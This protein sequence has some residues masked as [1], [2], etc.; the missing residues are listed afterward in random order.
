MNTIRKETVGK[1]LY[2]FV[3]I[4]ILPVSLLLWAN[5]TQ[6]VVRIQPISSVT[7]GAVLGALG[8]G[9]L[10]AG[11]I[12]LRV[13]GKGL[14]MNLFPPP[15]FVHSGIYR[16]TPHPIYT[17]FS[18]CCLAT[19]VLLRSSSGFWFIS[20]IA[21]LGCVA[22]VLGFERQDLAERFGEHSD[23]CFLSL[24]G[25]EIRRPTASERISVYLLVLLPWTM[26]YEA[27]AFIGV[28]PDAVNG[29]L[30]M[31]REIPVV[32]WTEFFYAATY[33][34]VALLPL[35]AGSA[36]A[37]R[38]FSIAGLTATVAMV[39]FFIG[40]PLIAS[41]RDFIPHGIFGKL[42]LFER[43][44][45]TPAAA[46]PSYHVIWAIIGAH[47]YTES[48]PR[49]KWIWRT[50][51]GLIVL[52]CMTTGM[53]T[54]VDV[55]AGAV[56]GV[57]AA[58][59]DQMWELLRSIA[60][61]VSNSWKEWRFGKVRIINHGAYPAVGTALGIAIVGTLLGS[62]S[63]GYIILV[64]FVSLILAGLWAQVIEGSSM[65]LRPYGYYGGVLGVILGA[66][67]AYVLGGN[68]W[69]LLGAYAVA[70]PVIQAFGRI[71]CLVQG[72]CH[73]REAPP[74]IGIR[75]THPRSRVVRLANLSGVPVYPTPLYSIL[76]NAGL[77]LVL[78]RLWSLRVEP[79]FVAGVY[80][81]LNGLG[82]FVEEAYRGEPQTPILGKLRLYQIMAILSVVTGAVFTSIRSE[83]ARAPS[84]NLASVAAAILF[85]LVTWFALGVDFPESNRRFARLT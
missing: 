82:R 81:I 13:Y 67:I 80:L 23:R 61:R 37:L 74:F 6:A 29:L 46:F 48:F 30:P 64:A 69:G 41:P 9:L 34:F 3:F 43:S 14:P 85:G 49:L 38:R 35:V 5:V 4:V 71:R 28:P 65:L 79:S 70:A 8:V 55:A 19:S 78:L 73:G 52:S 59:Y 83:P 53:H 18:L 32:E 7:L 44:V 76:W 20:P 10:L 2:G 1:V 75:Y 24:P 47:A 33:I 25:N 62:D 26:A 51:A 17:G 31:D 56:V 54:I 11:M 45:D 16:F 68:V 57:A 63:I 40:I 12:S 58:R 42:L 36:R 72:C 50:L 77:E 66:C 39:F 22:L 27:F 15:L 60:E 21:A 84:P